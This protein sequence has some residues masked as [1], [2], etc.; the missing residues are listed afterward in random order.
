[1]SWTFK[2]VMILVIN[3]LGFWTFIIPIYTLLYLLDERDI[4]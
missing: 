2:Q 1:M 4:K 3:I